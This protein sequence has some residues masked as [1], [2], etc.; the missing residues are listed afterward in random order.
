LLHAL[1]GTVVTG[2]ALSFGSKF[3]HDVLD[4]VYGVRAAARGG[5]GEA[6]R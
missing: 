4:R 1:V 3:W 2:I 6:G 5:Q